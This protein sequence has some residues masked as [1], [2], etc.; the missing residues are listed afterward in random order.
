MAVL[1]SAVEVL[2]ISNMTTSHRSHAEEAVMCQI[3]NCFV[4][5]AIAVN[6]IAAFV[7][8]TIGEL[9]PIAV[10]AKRLKSPTI[11]LLLQVNA[12]VQPRKVADVKTEP[13]IQVVAVTC[14]KIH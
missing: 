5:H 3:F 13:P 14:I 1:V 2:Q 10:K 8:C 6:P 11:H 7:K 4:L 9:A 12:L